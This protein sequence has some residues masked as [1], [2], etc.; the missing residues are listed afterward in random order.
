MSGLGRHRKSG[1]WVGRKRI[2]AAIRAAYAA[3][4]GAAWEAKFTRPATLG[5]REARAAHAEW[6]AV[7][8]SRISV[9][10]AEVQGRGTGLTHKQAHALAG[11]GYRWK[12][13]RHADDPGSPQR[14]TDEI[15]KLIAAIADL[16]EVARKATSQ[17]IILKPHRRPV[18]PLTAVFRPPGS[19]DH[20]P[21]PCS[22]QDRLSFRGGRLPGPRAGSA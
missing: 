16:G 17:P 14:W 12:T 21:E 18:R 19:A 5:E 11:R 10:S 22:G 7:V 6:L 15:T 2:P 3:A 1:S 20:N 9:I 4:F 13:D 8:E